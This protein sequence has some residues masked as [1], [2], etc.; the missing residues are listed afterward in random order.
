VWVADADR[1]LRGV[2]LPGALMDALAVA[3]TAALACPLDERLARWRDDEP[4][5]DGSFEDVAQ[6]AAALSPSTDPPLGDAEK[7]DAGAA[8][9]RARMLADRDEQWRLRACGQENQHPKLPALFTAS[10]APDRLLE[11][12]EQWLPRAQPSA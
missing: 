9:L 10:L 8:R 11:A 4:L 12:I 6:A 2:S 3:P 7:G 1:Q 5:L